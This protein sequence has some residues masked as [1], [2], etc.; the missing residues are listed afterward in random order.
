MLGLAREYRLFNGKQIIGLL[1]NDF[2]NQ[3]AYGEFRGSFVRFEHAGFGKKQARILDIEGEKVLGS[4]DFKTSPRAAVISYEG[5]VFE[6]NT[7][8]EEKSGSWIVRNE[9]EES[10]YLT[11]DPVG[12]QGK[13]TDAYLPSVVLL[14]GLFVRGYFLKRKI[15]GFIGG[16][17][18]GVALYFL[19]G[20]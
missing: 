18:I 5:E 13:I 3:K 17:S 4:I 11:E 16:F 9:E 7:L 12:S 1:K 8:R 20:L 15:L 2:W 10:R 6:W 19:S 14:A